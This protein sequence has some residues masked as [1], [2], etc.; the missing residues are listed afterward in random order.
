MVATCWTDV[1]RPG[2]S[3]KDLVADHAHDHELV[4]LALFDGCQTNIDCRQI[5][6]LCRIAADGPFRLVFLNEIERN[7]L[8]RVVVGK[9][10]G[11][12]HR[13]SRHARIFDRL[14]AGIDERLRHRA[15]GMIDAAVIAL[16]L[17]RD[18]RQH[19]RGAGRADKDRIRRTRQNLQHR[20]RDRGIGAVVALAG[21]DI[22]AFL[23]RDLIEGIPVQIAPAIGKAD[24]SDGLHVVLL[25]VLDDGGNHDRDRVRQVEYPR[26]FRFRDQH[27]R[28][29]ICGVL[30]STATSLMAVAVI[31][32]G[33]AQDNVDLVL[34]DELARILHRGGRIGGVVQQNPSD[35]HAAERLRKHLGGI[36]IGNAVGG[37]AAGEGARQT[38]LDFLRQ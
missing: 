10:G 28:E 8:H 21:N 16:V 24:E 29:P 37:V 38:D 3:W 33:R 17:Q 31:G 19:R 7:L 22:D 15:V 12:Y 2:A 14:A 27:R 25:H 11:C 30:A 36:A 34:V 23:L 4:T 26:Q 1:R 35:R 5:A 9:I 13:T 18:M 20:R 6:G 32:R